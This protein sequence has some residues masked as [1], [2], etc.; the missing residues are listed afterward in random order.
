[1]AYASVVQV[2]SSLVMQV[3]VLFWKASILSLQ[4]PAT[5]VS[6]VM[7]AHA[8]EML[9]LQF[10]NFSPCSFALEADLLP[11]ILI[12]YFISLLSKSMQII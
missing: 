6:M 2:Q 8:S 4:S 9:L 1:M 5:V 7:S 12:L 3:S 11:N 10:F